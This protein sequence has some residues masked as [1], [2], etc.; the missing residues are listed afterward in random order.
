MLGYFGEVLVLDWG[1]ARIMKRGQADAAK[2]DRLTLVQTG[3]GQA[4]G[5]PGYMSVEQTLGEVDR[6]DERSDIWSLGAILYE[7]LTWRRAYIA[8]TTHEMLRA[9]CAGPPEDPRRRA[10]DRGVPDALA[11]TVNRALAT[12]PEQRHASV[13]EL[14]DEVRGWIEGAERREAARSFLDQGSMAWVRYQALSD[15][16][17]RLRSQLGGLEQAALEDPAKG[18]ALQETRD[19]IEELELRRADSF[20]QV[21]TACEQGLARDPDNLAGRSMLARAYLSRAEEAEARGDRLRAGYYQRRVKLYDDGRFSAE[22]SGEGAVTLATEPSHAVVTARRFERKGL[23][24]KLGKK[25]TLGETPLV[26][27]PLAPGSWL[28]TVEH[29]ECGPATYPVTIGRAGHW[30][31]GERALPLLAADAVPEGWVYVPAGEFE[32]GGDAPDTLPAGRTW[33]EGFLIQ[34]RPVTAGELAAGLG[35]E[36]PEHPDHAATGVTFA[37]AQAY[38]IAA[39]ERDGVSCSLP[40]QAQWEK[41]ARGVDGRTYPWGDRFDPSLCSTRRTTAGRPTPGPVG[42]V[43]TD[44]SVYGVRDLAGGAR[45]WCA[46]EVPGDPLSR[47]VRGGS[48]RSGARPCSAATYDVADA[49]LAD[50]QTGFRLVRHL[51]D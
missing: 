44:V 4:I 41:A 51:P 16:R 5:T 34:E 23:V 10:P 14:A 39:S 3:A 32:R 35:R 8:R 36:A 12:A 38:A 31:A 15:E 22:V 33:Q 2:I 21:L 19:R 9:V 49:G 37:D 46:D 40:T 50:D 45:E 17:S 30:D 25:R 26:G 27:R 43:E 48:W 6:L 42:A 47:Y 18:P 13:E 1:V 24:W 11:A 28:L 20:E 7:L 29:P